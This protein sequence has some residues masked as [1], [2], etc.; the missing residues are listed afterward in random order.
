MRIFNILV[1][2]MTLLV[3]AGPVT[4]QGIGLPSQQSRQ[5]IQ[6]HADESWN[7]TGMLNVLSRGAERT[8][9]RATWRFMRIP[10]T[11]HYRKNAK[12]G[13]IE[14]WR[15]VADRNARLITPTQKATGSRGGYNI[16]TGVM[17]LEGPAVWIRKPTGSR[18]E[19]LSSFGKGRA[20]RSRAD[21]RWRSGGTI[22]SGPKC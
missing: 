7:G 10:L 16:D 13:V 8:P 12:T 1:A 5:P 19:T 6:I 15:I 21:R 14:I 4:A 18:P 17:I 20:L 3:G 9:S 2:A 22:G 11:G